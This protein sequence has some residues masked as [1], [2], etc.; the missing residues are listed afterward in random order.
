MAWG[1]GPVL[2]GQ[3]RQKLRE[4]VV[5]YCHSQRELELRQT[6]LRETFTSDSGS[7][8]TQISL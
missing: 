4:T 3:S 5:I 1:G 6:D 8:I 7:L 2:I